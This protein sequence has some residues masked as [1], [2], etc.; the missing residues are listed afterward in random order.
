[1]DLT[2]R[3]PYALAV[4]APLAFA[5]LG[6]DPLVR[7]HPVARTADDTLVAWR[8]AGRSPAHVARDTTQKHGGSASG[9]VMTSAPTAD[10]VNSGERGGR[11][12]P[13]KVRPVRFEQSVNAIPYRER[14]LRV[15]LWV[16]TRL[17]DKPLK[18]MP[19]PEAYTFIEVAN[20]DGTVT[21]YEGVMSKLYGTTEWTRK[22]MVIE[23]PPDAFALSFG[24]SI[25]GP[26]DVWV[27]DA[28]VEDQSP[29]SGSYQK[30]PMFTPEQMQRATPEQVE[31]GKAMLA[32]RAAAMR[33]RAAEVVN[34][35]FETR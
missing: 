24:V 8:I 29:A 23:V 4:G 17:A 5:L 15:S 12:G 10:I 13:P 31:Q 25:T 32:R 18:D 30:V 7:A 19:V 28:A 22:V 6:R 26:G 34:G 16:R 1:M 21:R 35:D 3:L 27:D 14:R 11:G 20:E 2:S 33:E 9:H